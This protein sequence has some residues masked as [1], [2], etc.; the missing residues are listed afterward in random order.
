[1]ALEKNEQGRILLRIARTAITRALVLYVFL[2]RNY[3]RTLTGLRS[4]MVITVHFYL[5]YGKVF[6]NLGSFLQT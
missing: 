4:S 6:S 5:R 1:M 2:V 3:A